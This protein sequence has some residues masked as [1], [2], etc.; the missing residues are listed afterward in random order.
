M[1]KPF[2]FVLALLCRFSVTCV[3]AQDAKRFLTLGVSATAYS[4]TLSQAYQT[5]SP[6]IHLGLRLNRK[7][8]LNGAFTATLGSVSGHSLNYT[9]NKKY[10]DASPVSSF[11]TNF[12]IANYELS[13]NLI[14]KKN[15]TWYL[16]QGFG[17]MRFEPYSSDGKS[18]YAQTTSRAPGETYNK[19]TTV[20]P[21][22]TGFYGLLPNGF[23]L[24]FQA[25]WWNTSTDYIDNLS[26]L[27]NGDGGDNMLFYKVC[28]L[29]PLRD[30]GK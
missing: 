23:G 1:R 17:L 3:L 22:G 7:K 30:V 4:G 25:G 6:S 24:G 18:L 26:K 12:F 28:L 13:Y 21:F 2:L 11:K 27:G 29:V 9:F 20:L 8:R 19:I 14:R 16:S 10:P 5:F 15:F